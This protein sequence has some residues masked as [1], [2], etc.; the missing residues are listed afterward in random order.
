[1]AFSREFIREQAKEF[2]IELP[3][4]FI[5]AMANEYLTAK[6]AYADEQ[7][8]K[9]VKPLNDQIAD[10]TEKLKNAET[11]N[12]ENAKYK[13]MYENEKSEYEKYKNDITAKET[14]AAKESAVWNY[15]KD[16][17]IPEKRKAAVMRGIKEE[18]AN[19][20][21]TEK[22]KIK[23]TKVFDDLIGEN[24]VYY[25]FIPRTEIVGAN[26]QVPPPNA[27]GKGTKTKAEIM[28]IKD[29]SERIQAIKDNPE[30]FGI[31]TKGE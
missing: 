9:A 29:A 13:E 22:G 28:A 21:L 6:K 25:D 3:K 23:N 11:Q 20:E 27:N 19:T 15:L 1:M 31:N 7:I 8:E 26:P 5:D 4:G 16:K 18:I 10:I 30:A 12:G 24:G 14:Q 17:G 2:E